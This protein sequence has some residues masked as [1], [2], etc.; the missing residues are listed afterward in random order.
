MGGIHATF[1]PGAHISAHLYDLML[2]FHCDVM[3]CTQTR[4][5]VF[6]NWIFHLILFNF[7][8]GIVNTVLIAVI[9]L[10]KKTRL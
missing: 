5:F 8:R 7:G 1:R 2:G 9:V 4:R 10:R 6:S 3:E